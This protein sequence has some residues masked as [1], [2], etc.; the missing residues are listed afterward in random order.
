MG[1]RKEE[2]F[3]F[4]FM[5]KEVSSSIIERKKRMIIKI[6]IICK[7]KRTGNKKMGSPL[8]REIEPGRGKG[9]E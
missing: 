6:Y 2:D 3:T 5:Q 9:H 1:G 8:P 4:A 7:G